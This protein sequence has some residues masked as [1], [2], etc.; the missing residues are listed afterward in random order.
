[1][2]SGKLLHI[3][4]WSLLCIS[5]WRCS[6]SPQTGHTAISFYYWKT[7]F[8]LSPYEQELLDVYKVKRLYVRYFDIN[9][10]QDNEGQV[11]AV[12][13]AV[14]TFGNNSVPADVT[15]IPVIFIKNAVMENR[16]VQL[17]SL[18][19]RTWQLISSINNHRAINIKQIQLDCDWTA[20]SGQRF[21]DFIEKLSRLSEIKIGSTVRLHQVKHYKVTGMPPADTPV[22]MYYNMG[23][24]EN[25]AENSI[26][27]KS[28]A[29]RYNKS[30][31]Y[32]PKPLSVAIPIYSWFI[33]SRNGKV[34][35]LY[36]KKPL[37][38]LDRNSGFLKKDDTFY[39]AV[40]NH[41]FWGTYFKKGDL[42]QYEHISENDLETIF[43]DLGTYLRSAP[44]EIILYDLDELNFTNQAY[45][46]DIF[47]KM[48]PHF[49]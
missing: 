39:E 30:L 18:A 11:Q 31:R 36:S 4:F 32:Y 41:I 13:Q 25:A 5:G 44:G 49:N 28:I 20:G 7:H 42:L 33:H 9:V 12:P 37:T 35:Q 2:N 45:E 1:M 10:I 23:S 48:V 21:F 16:S 15:I 8:E 34:L 38:E 17:D 14:I 19:A 29:D 40:R 43:T 26:Y 27:E 46:K 6:T 22:L 47:K 24:I 3:I